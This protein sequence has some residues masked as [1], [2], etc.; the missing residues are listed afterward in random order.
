MHWA[1]TL[2][3]QVIERAKSEQRIANV[4]CQQTPSGGKHIGNLNDVVRAYFPYKAVMERG[5]QAT[6]VHTSDDRD[7]MKEIPKRVAD[8]ECKWFELETLGDFT[9]HLGKPYFAVPDPFGCCV[10]W[11][12]HFTTVW[13][14]G[15]RALGMEPTLYYLDDL[16]RDGSMTPFVVKM[17]ERIALAKEIVHKYQETKKGV[18]PYNAICEKCGRITATVTGFD[19]DAKTIDYSCEGKK[20]KKREAEGCGHEG[21]ASML[22]GKLTWRFEWPALWALFH[23]TYEPF[24]KDHAEG[25]WPSGQEIARR[26]YD[27]EPPIPFVYE[28]FLV[29]GQKMSASKGNVYIVQ[30]LLRIVEREPFIY[31]YTKKPAKQR[32]MDLQR[33]FMLT[34]EYEHAER[35]Y[36]GIDKEGN[37]REAANVKRSYV[38]ATPVIPARYIPHIP[39][40]T[41]VTVA[42]FASTR[43]EAIEM[44]R[45]TGHLKDATKDEEE[46]AWRRVQL[47]RTW[48]NTYASEH[49]ITVNE[50]VPQEVTA[51][52]TDGQKRALR[53]LAADLKGPKKWDEEALQQRVY[54]LK[55][56]DVTAKDVFAALYAALINK[57]T[58][59][60]AGLLI[61]T[62]GTDRV[63]KILESV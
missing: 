42:Q 38:L 31:F 9:K 48:V 4:K 43:G 57:P 46:F 33:I 49:K 8:L 11:S 20:L 55:D 59:P 17:F 21:T 6:F 54:A 45:Q 28:F 50:S 37:E 5:E 16:Y 22:N 36:F 41:C 51:K 7:P 2:A 52:L 39:Y 18:I 40:T 44:L 34:D 63:R 58:G 56:A 14:D 10:S 27:I 26:I 35:V 30:D 24:G 3:E 32:D 19:L 53:A 13:M 12:R 23:T 29:S 1:D 25:S 60:R 61:K 47:A 15:I 62:L